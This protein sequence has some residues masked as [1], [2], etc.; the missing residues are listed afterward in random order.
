LAKQLAFVKKEERRQANLN[1]L[2]KKLI[3]S[4]ANCLSREQEFS[5]PEIMT[6][7]MGWLDV[8]LSHYYVAIY[9][10]AA[11]TALKKTF[12]GINPQR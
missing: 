5:A 8:Y 6:Y 2:N 9:W 1:K 10:D 4:C 7:I 12:P 11:E 3:Q